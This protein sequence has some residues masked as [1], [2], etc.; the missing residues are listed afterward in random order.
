MKN[1]PSKTDSVEKKK[2]NF[3]LNYLQRWFLIQ[4]LAYK[5]ATGGQKFGLLFALLLST[6]QLKK[7]T[8]RSLSFLWK[9]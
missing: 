7:K 4:V 6:I 5:R 1:K 3:E 2:F 8:K 9:Q